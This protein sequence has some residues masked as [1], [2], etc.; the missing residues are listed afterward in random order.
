MSS[1]T[2]TAPPTGDTIPDL[3]MKRPGGLAALFYDGAIT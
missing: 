2:S 1:E 3:R